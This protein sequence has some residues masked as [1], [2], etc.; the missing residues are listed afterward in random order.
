VGRR[1]YAYGRF[2][3]P[4][5]I[6]QNGERTLIR[7]TL[8]GRVKPIVLDVG[9][10]VGEWSRA[11]IEENASA[12]VFA[13]EPTPESQRR[14]ASLP[15]QV[16]PCAVS[17]HVGKAKFAIR[18]ATAGTNSLSEEGV[19]VDV[20]TVADF[21]ARTNLSTID[22]LKID[23]EG[24]DLSVLRGALPLL[25][26]K[27]I[28]VAQFEYNQLWINTRTVLKDVFELVSG[29]PYRVGKVVAPGVL[30]YCQWHFELDR[31][32]EGNYVLVREDMLERVAARAVAFDRFNTYG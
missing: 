20:T 11:V 28:A 30:I 13:F 9:A 22:L 6:D 3:T 18:G 16:I 23:V 1:L 25:H 17:D 12:Q 29:L 2:E 4:N 26:D 31:Y 10:N 19:D 24:Y 7:N 27:A 21:A 32:F 5:G 14:L 8:G 15:I